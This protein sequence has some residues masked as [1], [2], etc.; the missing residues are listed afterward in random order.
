MKIS[1]TAVIDS[2]TVDYRPISLHF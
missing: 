1:I 2:P